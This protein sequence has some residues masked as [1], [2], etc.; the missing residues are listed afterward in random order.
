MRLFTFFKLVSQKLFSKGEG[1][2]ASFVLAERFAALWYPKIMIG[3]YGKIW[4]E[5]KRFFDYLTKFEADNTSSAER[6]YFLRSLLSLVDTLP[7]DTAE[8]GAYRGASSWLI[9]DRFKET[10]KTHYVF[11]SCEGLS[12][13]LSVDGGYWTKGDLRGGEEVLKKNL[14]PFPKAKIFR[15]WIPDRF[16]E[17][18]GSSFCFVHIDVDLYQ[19]TLDSLGFFYP[20]LV[21]G[22]IILCDDYGFASCPGAKSAFDEYM[23]DRPEK[24]VHAPTGQAFIIKDGQGR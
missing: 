5:D 1:D 6:K 2:Y 17:A 7:G 19:P 22:G 3:Q 18:A 20:R 24:I 12:A 11:D 23:K 10:E 16:D 13:P 8:C 9:C 14:D 21:P 15:G 4:T